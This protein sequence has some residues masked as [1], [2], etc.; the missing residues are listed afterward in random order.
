[1]QPCDAPYVADDYLKLAR[2]VGIRAEMFTAEGENHG[3]FNTERWLSKITAEVHYD[4]K[5]LREWD[6]LADIEILTSPMTASLRDTEKA[7]PRRKP[8]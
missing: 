5:D 8:L 4:G 1:M 3:F 2:E 7:Y 6:N